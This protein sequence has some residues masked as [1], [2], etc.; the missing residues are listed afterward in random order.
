MKPCADH[1]P[2]DG[3]HDVRA[4]HDVL[5]QPL[6][7]QIQEAIGQPRLFGIVMVAE[8]RQR[9]FLRLALD[10]RLPRSAAR[11]RRSA[12]RAFTVSGGAR[13]HFA[14][15]GQHPFRAR[16]VH[17]G[18]GRRVRLDHALGDAV[19]VAQIDEDQPAMVAPA[20]DPARQADGLCRHRPCA[21]RRRY[22]CDRRA[23]AENL[24]GNAGFLAVYGGRVKGGQCGLA[25]FSCH[26]ARLA[27]PDQRNSR[28]KFAPLRRLGA[29][30]FR[31]RRWPRR[32]GRTTSSSS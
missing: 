21:A 20:V 18:E 19:M 12:G 16:R 27:W 14:R 5:V 13:H 3:R 32:P 31:P 23:W 1:A 22:G 8:H 29:G 25:G 7:A 6:A 2:A 24:R 9:Q 28:M 4:Q 26:K 10:R 11:L 30:L 17:R 15:K